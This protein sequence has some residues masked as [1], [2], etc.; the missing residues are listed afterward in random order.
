MRVQVKARHGHVNDSVRSYAEEKLGKLGSP[1]P[2]SH[3]DRGDAVTGAQP[4][5]RGR[6]HRRGDRARQRPEH[7][8]ARAGDDLGGGD[9][10]ADRQARAAGRAAARHEDA[11][12]QAPRRR[13]SRPC[14]P[15][16]SSRWWSW[17]APKSPQPEPAAPHQPGPHWGEVGIHGLHRLREWDAVSLVEVPAP[18]RERGVRRAARRL[19]RHRGRRRSACPAELAAALDLRP[20]LP[21]RGD[22]ASGVDVGRRRAAIEVVEL[23]GFALRR[24]DRGRLG[25]RRAGGADR[26]RADSVVGSRAR[27]ARLRPVRHLGGAGA[28]DPRRD[29]GGRGRRVVTF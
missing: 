2:R 3:R 12:A 9:R 6:P 7:R 21:G 14:P 26:R 18:T 11:R 28:E 15:R 29:L 25:R 23:P 22:P 27:A 5:D 4:L 8:R 10:P 19:V 1:R 20:P 13:A 24:G 16:S 17:A